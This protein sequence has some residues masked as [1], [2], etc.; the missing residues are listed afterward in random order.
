LGVFYGVACSDSRPDWLGKGN[1]AN[2]AE[3]RA[4]RAGKAAPLTDIAEQLPYKLPSVSI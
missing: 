1:G 2:K 4:K 3:L